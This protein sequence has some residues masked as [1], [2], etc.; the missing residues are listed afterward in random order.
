M[1]LGYQNNK[2]VLAANTR[3]ELENA[4]CIYFDKV[5]ETAEEY[6]LYNGQY[7]LKAVAQAAQVAVEKQARINELELQ[8]DALDLKTVRAL[9]AIQAGTSTAADNARLA[10]LETQAE[11]L[12]Q[13]MKEL[14]Q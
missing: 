13:Q 12:R 10:E 11:G 6:V 2:I 4:P 9:R 3:K 5:E 14:A 8:L 7:M 1:F